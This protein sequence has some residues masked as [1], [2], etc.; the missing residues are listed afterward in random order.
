MLLK[1]REQIS[2]N[3]STKKRAKTNKQVGPDSH[4][5]LLAEDVAK[6]ER[7]RNLVDNSEDEPTIALGL[8]GSLSGSA[9]RNTDCISLTSPL[10]SKQLES[11]DTLL[12]ESFLIWIRH[13]NVSSVYTTRSGPGKHENVAASPENV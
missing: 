3:A 1:I 7:K 5:W 11:R 13:G 12:G 6:E 2:A 10:L 9:V 4:D 8:H